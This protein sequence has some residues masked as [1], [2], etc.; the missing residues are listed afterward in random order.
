M[1]Y[2]QS[3]WRE[4]G[5]E[6][7]LATLLVIILQASGAALTVYVLWRAWQSKPGL[8]VAFMAVVFAIANIAPFLI[9]A[10]PSPKPV[11][12]PEEAFSVGPNSYMKIWATGERVHLVFKN[13]PMAKIS[14][15][16][17][18]AKELANKLSEL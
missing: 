17:K 16:K 1:K 4:L 15:D 18:I 12:I 9:W 11:E 6:L 5:P 10:K 14:F 2:I 8:E 7:F 13:I 3:Q